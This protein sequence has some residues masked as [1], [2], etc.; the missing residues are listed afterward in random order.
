MLEIK[1]KELDHVQHIK[2]LVESKTVELMNKYVASLEE[3]NS[4]KEEVNNKC[5]ICVE[6]DEEIKNFNAKNLKFS[7]A[8]IKQKDT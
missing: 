4:L 5:E 1:T 7:L 3:L 8:E 2:N 6:K